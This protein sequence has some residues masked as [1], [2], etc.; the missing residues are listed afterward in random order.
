MNV[1]E[2][3]VLNDAIEHFR[4]NNNEPVGIII[5]TSSGFDIA[6]WPTDQIQKHEIY[7]DALDKFFTV[8]NLSPNKHETKTGTAKNIFKQSS[9]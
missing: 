6:T 4:K 5:V 8:N 7:K 1:N 2:L 9:N 3:S